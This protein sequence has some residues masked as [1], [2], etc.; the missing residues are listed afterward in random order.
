V[1]DARRCISYWT[2]EQ[3]EAPPEE[4]RAAIGEHLFGCDDCQDACPWNRTAPPPAEK[5]APFRPLDR[6]GQLDLEGLVKLPA[7]RW[8]EVAAGSP[9]Y[10]AHRRGVARNAALVA[11]N[12][13]SRGAGGD[14][15]RRAVEAA[16]RHD[17]AVV[18]AAV[19]RGG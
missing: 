4:L 1:L 14:A 5:T 19:K 9:V 17:E 12:R 13:L 8:D 6:W 11:A 2:I 7:E 3:P 10:R 16:E 15:E 18:R